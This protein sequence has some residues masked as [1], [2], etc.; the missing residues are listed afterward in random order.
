M[1]GLFLNHSH[2]VTTIAPGKQYANEIADLSHD[3]AKEI[4]SLCDQLM[5]KSRKL[6]KAIRWA[7]KTYPHRP[8]PF[9]HS[10]TMKDLLVEALEEVDN[11]TTYFPDR[12][13]YAHYCP[14]RHCIHC[15]GKHDSEYHHLSLG[16][17]TLPDPDPENLQVTTPPT[18]IMPKQDLLQTCDFFVMLSVYSL[19]TFSLLSLY[20][21]LFMLL[22]TL[23]FAFSHVPPLLSHVYLTFHML[24]IFYHMYTIFHMLTVITCLPFITCYF[25]YLDYKIPAV[26]H[27]T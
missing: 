4:N 15:K 20:F 27:R 13:P 10:T 1:N 16:I 3:K 5:S 25:I 23:D 18:A 11:L 21:C 7:Q 22:S 24:P 12:M 2:P 26:I 9:Q 19:F 8:K 17:P 6:L 14:L